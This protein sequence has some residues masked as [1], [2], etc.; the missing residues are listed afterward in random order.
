MY[1]MKNNIIA[2]L[3]HSVKHEYHDRFRQRLENLHNFCPNDK[4]GVCVQ[5]KF[6]GREISE[7][8]TT[9]LD[10]KVCKGDRF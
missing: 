3:Q 10:T 8:E 1:A 2:T 7:T 9:F 4:G 5:C 6:Y